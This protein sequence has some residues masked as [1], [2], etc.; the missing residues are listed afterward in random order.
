MNVFQVLSSTMFL[1]SSHLFVAIHIIILLDLFGC[2]NC[3][4][5]GGISLEELMVSSWKGVESLESSLQT[6]QM[7]DVEAFSDGNIKASSPDS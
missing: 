2:W 4:I 1:L 3:W 6:A 5:D 7:V